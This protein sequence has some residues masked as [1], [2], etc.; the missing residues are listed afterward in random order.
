MP[1]LR[2]MV[3]RR[4]VKELKQQHINGT[5]NILLNGC[6]TTGTRNNGQKSSGR[7]ESDAVW[8]SLCSGRFLACQV[9]GTSGLLVEGPWWKRC[10]LKGGEGGGKGV[11]L[12]CQIRKASEVGGKVLYTGFSLF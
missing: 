3:Q 6:T 10:L 9:K 4:G 5:G 1:L 11:W 7:P 8:N 2:N 12:R